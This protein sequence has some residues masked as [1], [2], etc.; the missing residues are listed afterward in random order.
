MFVAK[1]IP[2]VLPSPSFLCSPFS[3]SLSLFSRFF[4]YCLK[5]FPADWCI[6]PVYWSR[7]HSEFWDCLMRNSYDLAYLVYSFILSLIADWWSVHL[8]PWRSAWCGFVWFHGGSSKQALYAHSSTATDSARWPGFRDGAWIQSKCS[9]KMVSESF[10]GIRI[11]SAFVYKEH[12]KDCLCMH[13]GVVV[14]CPWAILID[15]PIWVSACNFFSA[16]FFIGLSLAAMHYGKSY[17][18]IVNLYMR[19]IS[20]WLIPSLKAVVYGTQLNNCASLSSPSVMYSPNSSL[21]SPLFF[22]YRDW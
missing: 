7:F 8:H 9:F 21:T 22:K 18:F 14:S 4:S 10:L 15:C 17:V 12:F 11:L 3:L 13:W 16:L 6:I 2:I 1:C 19:L 20:I 5:K